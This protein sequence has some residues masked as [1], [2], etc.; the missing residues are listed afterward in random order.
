MEQ[1]MNFI[2]LSHAINERMP[3]F[4]GSEKPQLTTVATYEKDGYH[5]T[6]IRMY[7]HVGTHIDPPAHVYEKGLTL[8]ALPLTQFIG[9]ALVIDCRHRKSEKPITMKEVNEAREDAETAD[10]LLFNTGWDKFWGSEEYFG[11]YPC[12]DDDVLDFILLGNYKGIGFDVMG[13]DPISDLSL[14]RH[15]KLFKN[16]YIINIENLANLDQCGSGLFN[17]SCFPL[18]LENA[19]G[20]PTR[21][22]AWWE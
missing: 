18:K 4:P 1:G 22:V 17:F 20:A 7:S 12:I 14:H 2:D 10:F 5:E 13:I 11:D 3:V 8:D 9:Q 15:K 6:L 19:D 16:K 21:A